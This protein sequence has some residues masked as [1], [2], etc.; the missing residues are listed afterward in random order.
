MNVKLSEFPVQPKQMECCRECS[1]RKKKDCEPN[2]M[3]CIDFCIANNEFIARKQKE[4][5]NK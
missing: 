3:E 1:G 2:P 5:L 4:I